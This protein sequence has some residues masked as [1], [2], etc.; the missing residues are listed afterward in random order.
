MVSWSLSTKPAESKIPMLVSIFITAK[1][2]SS[3]GAVVQVQGRDKNGRTSLN[4]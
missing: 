4:P 1:Q 3:W 2:P